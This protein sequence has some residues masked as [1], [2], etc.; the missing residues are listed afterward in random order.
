MSYHQLVEA[1]REHFHSGATRSLENRKETLK[2]YRALLSENSQQLHDAIYQ[3][4]H[5][6]SDEAHAGIRNIDELLGGKME[7][8]GKPVEVGVETPFD[9]NQDKAYIVR[10][11]LGVVLVISPWNFPL[12]CSLPSISALASGN[13]VI[14]KTSELAPHYSKTMTA[15]V[16]KYF[17]PEVFTVVEGAVPEVTEL[18]QE[19]FDHIMYTGNPTVGK[20]IMTAAAKNLTPVTLELGGKN[21]VLVEPDADL[22]D[23]AKKIVFSKMFNCG[24][25]CLSSDYVLTTAETKPKLVEALAKV[26]KEASPLK[27]NKGFARI[28]HE[29]H[30]DRLS[31]LLSKT[32]GELLFEAEERQNREEKFLPPRVYGIKEDD[33]LMSEEIFGPILPIITVKDFDESLKFVKTHEKPLGAYIF[34]K[35]PKKADRFVRETYSGGVTINDVM[36]HAFMTNVPFGGVGNSGMGKI[37]GRHGFQAFTHEKVV[38]V[39]NDLDIQL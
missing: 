34:T 12:I 37:H 20:I 24:Q 2:N 18:L 25:I 29:R 8:W 19:R 28:I 14:L 27:D 7:E 11:P 31:T 13:T 23:T 1:Q 16:K 30:F 22:E 38:L 3:D 5:R 26:Y 9:K 21:P 10:E 39:R 4:L 15:L 35:D 33:A 36:K 17:A 6:V 32:N